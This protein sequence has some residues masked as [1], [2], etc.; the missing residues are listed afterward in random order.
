MQLNNDI[1]AQKTS[2]KGSIEVI[3]GS[4]FSGKTEELINRLNKARAEG[5]SVEIFTPAIDT[6]YS[7]N[8]IVSH[9]SNSIPAISV[10]KSAE[11]LAQSELATVVGIDEAQFFDSELPEICSYLANKGIKVI[12]AGLDMDFKA[13]PFG[14]VPALMAI[15]ESVTKLHA[16]CVVCGQPAMYSYRIVPGDSQVLLG[17][18]ESYEAR[19]RV[20]FNS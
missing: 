5:F 17:E 19:C 12:V 9:D 10:T 14:T 6:R 13:Q 20:H 18:N 8:A 15:A 7:R 3:C 11:I 1:S 16:K 4:M 2:D